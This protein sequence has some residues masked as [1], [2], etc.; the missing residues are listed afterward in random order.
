[1]DGAAENGGA[2]TAD[3]QKMDTADN[4]DVATETAC[5]R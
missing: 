1:M 5:E 2:S 3:A 4:G